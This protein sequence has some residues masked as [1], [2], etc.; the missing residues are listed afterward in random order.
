MGRLSFICSQQVF[1]FLLPCH[2]QRWG[3]HKTRGFRRSV[4]M[5]NAMSSSTRPRKQRAACDRCHALKNRCSPSGSGDNK[6]DRCHRL[7]IRCVYSLKAPLGRPK[8]TSSQAQP[9]D[10]P[11][12]NAYNGLEPL[13]TLDN[14][15]SDDFSMTTTEESLFMPST[16]PSLQLGLD[17]GLTFRPTSPL[18]YQA[19][20]AMQ[21]L[22]DTAPAAGIHRKPHA[23]DSL[24]YSIFD[25]EFSHSSSQLDGETSGASHPRRTSHQSQD[26][27]ELQ[28]FLPNNITDDRAEVA[29]SGESSPLKQLLDLQCRFQELAN[30]DSSYTSDRGKPRSV[31]DLSTILFNADS[32]MRMLQELVAGRSEPHMPSRQKQNDES[33]EHGLIILHA[34]TCY[35]YLLSILEPIVEFL[36]AKCGSTVERVNSRSLSAF[37]LGSFSLASQP[38]INAHVTLHLINLLIR[39]LRRLVSSIADHQKPAEESLG[40]SPTN[41][42]ASMAINVMQQKETSILVMLERQAVD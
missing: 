42:A 36:I 22:P 8:S 38:E 14:N 37:S 26:T 11:T 31:P 34:L 13:A 18:S 33:D 10:L 24:A 3:L 5:N 12:S 15:V 41:G 25:F 40:S 21:S 39:K 6:C 20:P 1:S 30:L 7:G 23:E 27:L 19:S 35:Y 17:M 16:P 4:L 29:K 32:L 2:I 28:H 9:V